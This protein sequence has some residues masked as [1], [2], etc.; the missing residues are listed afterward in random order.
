MTSSLYILAA[1]LPLATAYGL[2]VSISRGLGSVKPLVYIEKIGCNTLQTALVIAALVVTPSLILTVVAWSA[3][4][5]AASVMMG[6]TVVQLARS[7]LSTRGSQPTRSRRELVREFWSFSAPRAVSRLF[8]VGL[9]RFDILLVSG[10]KGLTAAAIYAAASRFLLLGLMFVQAIQQVMAP[11]VS[12][13]LARG[14]VSRAHVLYETTTAW[15]IIIAWPIYLISAT[16]VPPHDL[17]SAVR[18]RRRRRGH[19]VPRNARGDGVWSG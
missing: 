6:L 8:A 18:L 10:M 12:E 5:A 14:D 15:L 19:P 16:A 4:Y 9:Q 2:A 11:R 17:R 13:F 3:P 1:F 7:S